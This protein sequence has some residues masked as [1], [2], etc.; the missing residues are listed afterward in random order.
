MQLEK[1]KVENFKNH[2]SSSLDC[3]AEFVCFWGL[4]G[5]GKTNLLDAI[6]YLSTG[7]SYFNSLDSQNIKKG[8]KY[9]TLSGSFSK[10]SEDQHFEIFCGFSQEKK[11]VLKSDGLPYDRIS[12]HYGKFPAV[13]IAPQD[14]QLVTEAHDLRRRFVD[15]GISLFSQ[16][17]LNTLVKHNK[18]L[19]QR[20]ALLKKAQE[21]GAFD[22]SLFEIY[23]AQLNE[24]AVKIHAER[25]A[26]LE[27]LAPKFNDFM[28]QINQGYEQMDIS[29]KSDLNEHSLTEL[30]KKYS[31][32]ERIL[33][34]TEYG[35]HKD[36][37]VFS[38]NQMPLKKFGSQG[39]Q[40]SYVLALKLAKA[41]LS[42]SKTGYKPILLLDDFFDRLDTERAE[43]LMDLIHR[44]F[45]QKFITDTTDHN[46]NKS[47]AQINCT[48][49]FYKVEDGEIKKQTRHDTT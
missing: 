4:N 13:L 22:S 48:A 28:A 31:E 6:H 27:E 17:Y 9:F 33:G 38:I 36:K 15:S 34:R 24:A 2:Q 3:G 44:N 35:V 26:Y 43:R 20:N 10:K 21:G 25:K 32:K 7:K 14:L 19:Q 5:S 16:P 46:L 42:K 40:K 1:F 39:Q 49:L 23:N 47:F 37:I 12:E 45:G 41:E 30:W 8:E 18:I 11:K 29:Y